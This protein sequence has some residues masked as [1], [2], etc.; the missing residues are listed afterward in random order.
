VLPEHGRHH[1]RLFE[2]TA[3]NLFVAEFDE[4]EGTAVASLAAQVAQLIDRREHAD[5]A[6]E[7]LL[8][9]AYREDPE[10]QADYRAMTE[11][12]LANRK[13]SNSRLIA[14]A[15]SDGDWPRAVQL[16]AGIAIRWMRALT[17]I[18]LVLASRIGIRDDGDSQDDTSEGALFLREAYEVL[19]ALQESLVHAMDE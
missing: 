12:D 1:V 9:A 6:L 7:R 15:L 8:P 19:G 3:D 11:D 13:V 18:R 5:P 17:D 4:F 14:H 16:D 2:R 10:A